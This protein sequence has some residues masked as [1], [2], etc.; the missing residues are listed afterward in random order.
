VHTHSILQFGKG[1]TTPFMPAASANTV[2][3]LWRCVQ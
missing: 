2:V 1:Y 3:I